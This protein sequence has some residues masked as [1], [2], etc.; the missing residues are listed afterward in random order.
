[1]QESAIPDNLQ[2][3]SVMSMCIKASFNLYDLSGLGVMAHTSDATL[4]VTIEPTITTLEDAVTLQA[5]LQ[6]SEQNGKKCCHK[7]RNVCAPK[8]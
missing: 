8:I 4:H 1:M 3:S 5:T 6:I 2:K 7:C